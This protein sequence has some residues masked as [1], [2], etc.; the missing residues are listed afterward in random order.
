MELIV[1]GTVISLAIV[2]VAKVMDKAKE[3]KLRRAIDKFFTDR[4]DSIS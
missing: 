3:R 1:A 4:I 2:V